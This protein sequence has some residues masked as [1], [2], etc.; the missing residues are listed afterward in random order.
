MLTLHLSES[1]NTNMCWATVQTVHD[2]HSISTYPT[3]KSTHLIWIKPVSPNLSVSVCWHQVSW[4]K[5]SF[6]NRCSCKKSLRNNITLDEMYCKKYHVILTS[7][8]KTSSFSS[9]STGHNCRYFSKPGNGCFPE[10]LRKGKDLSQLSWAVFWWRWRSPKNDNKQLGQDR[11]LI[12]ILV[13]F[14]FVA[15]IPF[16][17]TSGF[18]CSSTIFKGLYDVEA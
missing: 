5:V 2:N 11:K 15:I 13:L 10:S 18:L 7:L 3:E 8:V 6:P 9:V 17:K 16:Q 14:L 1:C 12:M 4:G